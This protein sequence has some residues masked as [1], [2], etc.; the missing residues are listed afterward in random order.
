MQQFVTYETTVGDLSINILP[1]AEVRKIAILDV[2]VMSPPS[3]RMFC[4]L[5]TQFPVRTSQL[6]R[7]YVLAS[8]SLL[9][10][11][12]LMWLTYFVRVS[13]AACHLC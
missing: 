3:P 11:T 7:R 12:S 1:A 5:S 10:I 8:L 4:L 13:F 2:Y 6:N 9:C